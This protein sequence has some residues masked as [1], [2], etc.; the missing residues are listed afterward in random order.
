[1]KPR[2]KIVISKILLLSIQ[3]LQI[4]LECN[5]LFR[6]LFFK[7]FFKSYGQIICSE[8]YLPDHKKTIKPTSIG[9]I[10]GGEKFIVRDILFKFATD[11]HG[12]YGGEEHAIKAAAHELVN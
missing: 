11:D 10:A 1:M 7:L 2:K 5:F 9:G 3:I 12:L 4:Q 8:R 6:F